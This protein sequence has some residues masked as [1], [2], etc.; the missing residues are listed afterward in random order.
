MNE[1]KIKKLCLGTVQFG[2][3]YGISNNTGQVDKE[4]AHNM[5]DQFLDAGGEKIDTAQGYGN[6]E[7]IIGEYQRKNELKIITKI[8]SMQEKDILLNSFNRL[9]V[10]KLYG[11]MCHDEKV[12]LENKNLFDY[13]RFKKDE[14]IVSKIGSSFYSIEALEQALECFD[15]DIIQIPASIFD[16]EFLK[17]DLL[18]KLKGKNIEIHVRSIF[19]QGLVFMKKDQI[20]SFFNPVQTKIDKY[21]ELLED[22]KDSITEFHFNFMAQYDEIDCLVVGFQNP[23]Q[24][25]ESIE[26][27][28][29]CKPYNFDLSQLDFEEECYRKPSHW[30]L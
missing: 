16:Q 8:S 29:K 10:E 23:V 21:R 3:N 22:S 4:I 13:L 24:L 12:F 1:D 15:L 17:K 19:L 18:E 26:A 9:G 30:K 20:N 2:L 5:L 25:G 6:S 11:V 28:S 27:I 14:G 7:K